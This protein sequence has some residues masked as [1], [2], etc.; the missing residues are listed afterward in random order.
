MT[1][2]WLF[3][4][5][6][7]GSLESFFSTYHKALLQSDPH[8]NPARWFYVTEGKD[9]SMSLPLVVETVQRLLLDTV[10]DGV[11]TEK[12]IPA[13][14]NYDNK[15]LNVVFVGD[16]EDVAT[17]KYF[18][19][20]VK[21]LLEHRNQIPAPNVRFYALLW[22][23][24]SA[25]AEP[26]LSDD[27]MRFVHELETLMKK[28]ENNRFHKVL[29]FESSIMPV[30]KE[31]ML[32]S[33][34]LAALHIAT[35]A[36]MGE[37]DE[38][39]RSYANTMYNAGAAGAF[40]EKRV[41]NEQETFYLS[42]I[43][44]NALANSKD[45]SFFNPNEATSY[46]DNNP[47]FFEQFT[48]Q[49]VES[50]LKQDTAQIPSNKDAYSVDSTVSPF[51][52]NFKEVWKKY[53]NDYIVNLKA[54]IINKTKKVLSEYA[55]NYKEILFASQ[56]SFVNSI[57]DEIES[58]VFEIFRNPAS[59]EAVSLPQALDILE[60][61]KARIS[62]KASE[63]HDTKVSSFIFPKYLDGAREQVEAEVRNNDPAEIISVLES[64]L[65]RH[66][67][68]LL[69]MFVRALVLGALLCYAGITFIFPDLPEISIWVVGTLLFLLPLG[70]SFWNFREYMVRI[71]SLKDQY[72]AA[73]LLKYKKELDADLKKCV[74]KSYDDIDKYCEW[75]KIHKLEFLQNKLS[76]VTPPEFSFTSS[77]RFQ[78]LMK[79][80]PYGTSNDGRVL[81]PAMRVDVNKE[82]EMSGSFGRYP[83]L[84]NPPASKVKVKGEQYTF[85]EIVQDTQR[86]LLRDLVRNM[87]QS[88]A[89]VKNNV[90]Q[91]V[92]FE[93]IRSPRT[94]LLLL[95]VSGSMTDSDMRELRLAVEKL[96]QT[97]TIKWIAFNDKVVSTGDSSD[98]FNKIN[99]Y[100][101]TN[102]IPALKKAKEISAMTVIDQIILISDGQPFE[103]VSDIV[104][105]AYELEQPVHTI[106]IGTS[107][108]SVMKEISDK[109][110]GEQII[111]KDLKELSV[112][113][114]SKFNVIFTLGF[115]GEYTF[116]ELMQKV[117][118]PGC[119]EA[120]HKF[121]SAQLSTGVT[122]IAE[123]I[124]TC[125]NNNG[126]SEWKRCSDASCTHSVAI[127]QKMS[128]T[129]VQ[130]VCGENEKDL[131]KR[132]FSETF[133]VDIKL[134]DTEG[135]PEIMVSVLTLRPIN[136]ITDIKWAG[137]DRVKN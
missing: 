101:G 105:V 26:G 65:K 126:M 27:S 13:W 131:V 45:K 133:G 77:A 72:V 76:A 136:A 113:V 89:N 109:T 71:N 93:A 21:Y 15:S 98:E 51:S 124:S 68:F 88:T 3:D 100:G 4:F 39:T 32:A 130:M 47:D 125:A 19:S 115:E 94:K 112:D 52:L 111:V 16:V 55:H 62:L 99:S 53:Y 63:A 42:N 1:P 107:G 7:K 24:D 110:S 73:V 84:D 78:P 127:A 41:Q 121:A 103:S 87:L 34:S 92:K 64:K 134:S 129:Y 86:N 31:K 91:N 85:D 54:N 46:L 22:R 12:L 123:L 43:L 61:I 81:I 20:S 67:V 117:Y 118:I 25:V 135:A 128:D 23:P 57:K 137:Y 116:G 58:K 60:K 114:V 40:Y 35:H 10:V 66:P 104:K 9:A 18:L 120:L 83:I 122:T 75:L 132:K 33:I 38:L 8:Q 96:A 6:K 29:F 14:D 95:D 50:A 48:S 106:S 30:E 82:S 28:N 37:G 108:A 59:Y 36:D 44:L 74:L 80:M 49:R 11:P 70:L 97:A 5:I 2:V 69:S 102:Y 90:E 119:A 79:C 56:V 17:H